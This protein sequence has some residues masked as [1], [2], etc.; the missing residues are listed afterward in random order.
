[1][2]LIQKDISL[3]NYN[4]LAVDAHAKYFAE[5]FSLDQLHLLMK[6]PL[7]NT[8]EEKLIL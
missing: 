1:M 7:R 3:L 6:E 8:V 2:V 5:V 4:T